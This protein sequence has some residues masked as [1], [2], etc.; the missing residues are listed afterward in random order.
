[1]YDL[2]FMISDVGRMQASPSGTSEI[3]NPKSEISLLRSGRSLTSGCS[4]SR[5][6]LRKLFRARDPY[7]ANLRDYSDRSA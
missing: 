1:M 2:G 5:D 6:K 7:Q 3:I 4:L